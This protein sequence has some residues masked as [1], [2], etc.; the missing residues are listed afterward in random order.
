MFTFTL[1]RLAFAVPTLLVIS[2]VIFALLD[3]APNDP[4]G[5]L[6][7]TIPPEVREQIRASLGLDQ[8]F[9][10][11]YLIWLQQFFINEPL[12][13]F[14]KLTGWQIGDG[15]RMRVLSWATRSPVV[16]L[17]IQRMPQT[18]W[19]VGLAYLFGA[20]LAIPIGVISAYKQYSIFDQIGTFVSMVGYSVPTFFTGV[21]LVVIFSSYLQWF[22]SVYDTNLQVTDWGSLVAQI[23]QMFMPVLVLTLYNVSQISRFVRASMLDN[24]HQDYVRTARAK[25]VKEKS[26]LLVHVLRNSLIP[27]VTVIALGVPTIFSGAIITEQIFRVNGL[28]QLLITAVQGADIPLV[29]TLTFIFAVL[30]VL[31]NLIADVLYGILDPRIRYD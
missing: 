17:V 30:I 10:I 20:L 25:G 13:L 9:F 22:P 31:F 28:G 11:R 21:L 1:R 26:V 5:D 7:L 15:S 8:P 14:E 4:T 29:Q 24:L 16:D 2:F 3:L 18:L 12:N 19:V 6:P 23:K 27:V